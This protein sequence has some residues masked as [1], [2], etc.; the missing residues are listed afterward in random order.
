VRLERHV[1]G[2]GAKFTKQNKP[3]KLLWSQQFD[4]ELEAIQREK[5][6]KGWSRTKKENL[7]KGLWK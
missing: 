4:T 3:E 5:Q 7:I 2:T 6:I 1:I